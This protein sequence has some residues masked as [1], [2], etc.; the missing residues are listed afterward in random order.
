MRAKDGLLLPVPGQVCPGAVRAQK[1][2]LEEFTPQPY[3][4]IGLTQKP[5]EIP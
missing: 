3:D 1:K 5:L 2:G 4:P